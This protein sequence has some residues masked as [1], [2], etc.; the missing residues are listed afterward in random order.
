MRGS[1]SGYVKSENQ[2]RKADRDDHKEYDSLHEEKIG[3]SDALEK[4]R[5]DAGIAE[6]DLNEHGA[7]YEP[8]ER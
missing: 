8:P 1:S 5:A 2:R 7:G 6:H 4:Q 3:A